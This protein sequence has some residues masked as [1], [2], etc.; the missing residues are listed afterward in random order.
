MDRS[1][2]GSWPTRQYTDSEVSPD[3]HNIGNG[4]TCGTMERHTVSSGMMR[5]P[6]D[7]TTEALGA[8]AAHLQRSGT[9]AANLGA[10]LWLA[11]GALGWTLWLV[12]LAIEAATWVVLALR[13]WRTRGRASG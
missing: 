5:F 13:R 6:M 4:S 7:T 12:K 2:C 1:T 11:M 8:L 10:L 9:T 3:Q